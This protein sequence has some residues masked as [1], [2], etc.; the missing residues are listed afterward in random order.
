MFLK[1]LKKLLEV[2]GQQLCSVQEVVNQPVVAARLQSSSP[3]E[4]VQSLPNNINEH[5]PHSKSG[6]DNTINSID[7]IYLSLEKL[8]TSTSSSDYQTPQQSPESVSR[9]VTD[10]EI[11]EIYSDLLSLSPTP[12]QSALGTDEHNKAHEQVG[13]IPEKAMTFPRSIRRMYT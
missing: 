10:V 3:V 7:T 2:E 4:L 6:Y 5:G 8:E 13:P 9:L 12:R 11:P 1:Q